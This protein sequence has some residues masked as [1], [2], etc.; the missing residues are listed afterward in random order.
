MD[1][2]N[3][4]VLFVKLSGLTFVVWTILDAA[5]AAPMLVGAPGD[6]FGVYLFTLLFRVAVGG[7]LW[8]LPVAISNTIIKESPLIEDSDRFFFEL[9]RSALMLMGLYLLYRGITDLIHFYSYE[10]SMYELLGSDHRRTSS[11]YASIVAAVAQIGISLFF[12]FGA[13]ALV[14]L[15]RRAWAFGR[16]WPAS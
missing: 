6:L 4:V 16:T 8:F 15:I 1:L 11:E 14:K 3:L 10:S 13:S 2:K 7:A 9:Q 12:M 5:S